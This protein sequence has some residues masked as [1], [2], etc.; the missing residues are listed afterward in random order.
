MG[1]GVVMEVVYGVVW[2]VVLLQCGVRVYVMV[3]RC[4]L[5]CY[6]GGGEDKWCGYLVCF[7]SLGG[8]RERPASRV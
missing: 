5:S 7:F 6:S 2:S 1:D 8:K 4:V 3:M